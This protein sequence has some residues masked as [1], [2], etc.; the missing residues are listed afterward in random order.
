[1]VLSR[2]LKI[3]CAVG[4]AFVCAV[5]LFA[6]SS[7]NSSASSQ[8][9]LTGGVAATVNGVEIPEDKITQYIQDY[10]TSAGY[11]ASE[12]WA[13]WLI[14][15][16]Y[17]PESVRL[18][19]IDF[20]VS[21]EL[22]RQAA[23]ENGITISE[24]EVDSYVQKVKGNYKTDEAWQNALK[25][26]NTTEADYRST[27]E[28]AL[29]Q[30][31][32][33]EVVIGANSPTDADVVKYAQENISTFNG[34]KRSSHILFASSDQATAQRVLGQINSG[35]IDFDSAAKQ[36]SQDAGSASIGGDVGWDK[37]SNFVTAYTTA[38]SGLQK[39]QIS[40]LVVSDYGIHVIKCTDIFE[41]SGTITSIGQLPSEFITSIRSALTSS[42]N[43]TAFSTWLEDF[44]SKA[45]IVIKDMPSN[46]PYYI[47]LSQYGITSLT[48]E[49]LSSGSNSSTEG[50]TS[51]A[52]GAQ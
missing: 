15:T 41:V 4:V 11:E 7:S 28:I 38:L 51:S 37:L 2:L 18:E 36:Y 32:L 1:M 26:A 40:G 3:T 45:D 46:V 35:E 24:S 49:T 34:A 48:E 44:K 27:I 9:G 47:D 50:E 29:M 23:A 43:S 20:H 6:C 19:I 10:R 31:R 16:G 13:N 33:Q 12:D 17:T 8:S 22:I 25:E 5:S 39:G 42:T 21:Q 30:Q 14:S 52:S